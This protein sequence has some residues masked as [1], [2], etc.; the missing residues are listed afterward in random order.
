VY[1]LEEAHGTLFIAMEYIEGQTLS[2]RLGRTAM[3][4]PEA[5][6]C[7]EQ[8]AAGLE[9]AHQEGVIHR[10]LKPCNAMFA[11]DGTVKVLDFGLARK[12][13]ERA[14]TGRRARHKNRDAD[15]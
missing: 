14:G 8:I 3:P 12:P 9:A 6:Y 4:I 10:D 5:L 13:R 2:Q 7:C 15:A 1:R 11:A